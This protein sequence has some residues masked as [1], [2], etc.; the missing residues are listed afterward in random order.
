MRLRAGTRDLLDVRL[1]SRNWVWWGVAGAGFAVGRQRDPD[2]GC[3]CVRGTRDLQGCRL[4]S[5]NGC[6]GEWQG[7]GSPSSCQRDPDMR[8]RAGGTRD[9]QGVDSNPVM[10]VVGSGRGGIRTRDLG[11]M[12]PPL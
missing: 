7:R 8:L 2:A 11:L 5:R 1:E 12:S 10:G 3:A 9:L 4:E 6:G